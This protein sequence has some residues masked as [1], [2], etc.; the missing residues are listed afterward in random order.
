MTAA[1]RTPRAAGWIIGRFVG[2][3]HFNISPKHALEVAQGGARRPPLAAGRTDGDDR[4][5][6]P[7]AVGTDER[8]EHAQFVGRN[9]NGARS[10]ADRCNPL[11]RTGHTIRSRLGRPHIRGN[12]HRSGSIAARRRNHEEDRP[13]AAGPVP[14][15]G[16]IAVLPGRTRRPAAA[17]ITRRARR[18]PGPP[19][20]STDEAPHTRATAASLRYAASGSRAGRATDRAR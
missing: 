13:I 12:R 8:G 2:S 16:C 1:R 15:A 7:T 11:S 20:R 5:A 6:R 10:G 19:R 3:G 14:A 17:T 9:A 4:R 18:R